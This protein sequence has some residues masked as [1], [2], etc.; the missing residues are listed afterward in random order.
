MRIGVLLNNEMIP[1]WAYAM[2]SEIVDDDSM[3]ITSLIIKKTSDKY[4]N[5]KKNRLNYITSWYQKYDRK[6]FKGNPDAF[7]QKDINDL[8]VEKKIFID[9]HESAN[10]S[11]FSKNA[12]EKIKSEELEILVKLGLGTLKGDILS[13]S[14]YGVW[15]II[16]EDNNLSDNALPGLWEVMSQQKESFI[17]LQILND[18]QVKNKILYKSSSLTDKLSVERNNNKNF[19]KAAS[20]IHREIKKLQKL[21]AEA[22]FNELNEFY[23]AETF[24]PQQKSNPGVAQSLWQIFK[25]N[26]RRIVNILIGQLYFDQW[27]LLFK[28]RKENFLD[29]DF[30]TFVKILPPKDRIWADPFVLKR[31]NKNYIFI[32]ELLFKEK[33]GYISVI[34]IDKEGNY[35]EPTKVLEEEYHLSY[36]FLIEDG[37]ELYMIPETKKNNK[38]QLY[39][40]VNFPNEWVLEKVLMDNIRAVDTTIIKDKDIFWLFTNIQNYQGAPPNDELYLFSSDNLLSDHW[41]PHP[42]NPISSDVKNAR[43]AGNLFKINNTWYRPAQ[44]CSHRYGYGLQLNEIICL[45]IHKYE[46]KRVRSVLPD[47]KNNILATHTFNAIEGLT[48]I[49]AQLR[50]IK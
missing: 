29:T 22:Y 30:N 13:V 47:E 15:A 24:Q 50:R 46:E 12:I 43:S 8:I 48:V 16:P 40:C 25:L 1:A 14:K 27:I 41:E 37:K 2:L 19:W 42:N 11:I 44:N 4:L 28:P 49:D 17:S 34:E 6:G 31:G 10:E 7:E 39:K 20:F 5:E 33:K 35:T 9:V 36:P 18:V 38:I 3:H 32:E 23:D 45:N 21:G 26:K